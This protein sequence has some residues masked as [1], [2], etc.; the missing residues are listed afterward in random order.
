MSLFSP[1]C[2]NF[3]SNAPRLPGFDP[4]SV[5]STSPSPTATALRT[6]GL[7]FALY[8]G[9]LPLLQLP[10]LGGQCASVLGSS[11]GKILG[12]PVG[13]YGALLWLFTLLPTGRLTPLASHALALG[14]I[15]F[16]ALQAFVL[17]QFCPWCLAHAALCWAAWPLRHRATARPALALFAAT[18]IA[19]LGLV[20]QRQFHRP[21]AI[22]ATSTLAATLHA[23]SFNW[24]RPADTAAPVLVLSPS[25]PTCLD[26]LDRF[27][28]EGWPAATPRPAI[29][30][31]TDA[32]NR[33]VVATL[34]AAIEAHP[35]AAPELFRA[36]LPAFLT[37]RD[38]LLNNPA[39]AATILELTWNPAP[40]AITAMEARLARQQAALDAAN[41]IG[42]PTWITPAGIVTHTIPGF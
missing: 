39:G 24:L 14:S 33:R 16:V 23:E 25:C 37:E 17:R 7:T 36:Y 4:V 41:L 42:T 28:A 34:A 30:W 31:R 12:V 2:A 15:G 32:V 3:G 27:V 6:A 26:A 10:C 20:A 22:A 18:I 29:I 19:A 38:L 1:S 5:S 8:L 21:P 40:A 9:A 13:V 35:A 11:Y